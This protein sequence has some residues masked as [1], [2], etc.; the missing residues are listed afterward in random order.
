[1]KELALNEIPLKWCCLQFEIVPYEEMH[2]PSYPAIT[3]RGGLGYEL[4]KTVCECHLESCVCEHAQ[5]YRQLYENRKGIIHDEYGYI[6]YNRPLIIRTRHNCKRKY[7]KSDTYVFEIIL[8]GEAIQKYRDIILAMRAFGKTGIGERM[9]KF[10]IKRVKS[11]GA[12]IPVTVYEDGEW[13]RDVHVNKLGDMAFPFEERVRKV[14][15]EFLTPTRLQVNGVYQETVSFE[16]MIENLLRRINS[17]LY[18]HQHHQLLDIQLYDAILQRAKFVEEVLQSYGKVKYRRFST[19]QHQEMFLNGIEGWSIVKGPEIHDL[20]PL[21]YLG[22]F[23]HIGKQTTF[24]FG[25]YRL[26]VYG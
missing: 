2:L 3:I 20:M 23:C 13:I 9:D 19:R 8:F 12:P 21:L 22:Q 11:L 5:F 17:L 14:K 10:Y 6:A 16:A 26:S 25:E 1:M 4:K 15:I 7:T 18:F 24:G